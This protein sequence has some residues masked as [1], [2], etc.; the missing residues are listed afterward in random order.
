VAALCETAAGT[1]ILQAGWAR[2]IVPRGVR[3]HAARAAGRTDRRECA[4]DL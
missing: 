4:S 1:A 3:D 2:L